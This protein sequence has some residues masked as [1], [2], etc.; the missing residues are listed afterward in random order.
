MTPTRPFPPDVF[1]FSPGLFYDLPVGRAAALP[2]V[3][4]SVEAR[5]EGEAAA[6][7]VRQRFFSRAEIPVEATYVFPLEEGAAVRGFSIRIGE[8]TVRGRILEGREAFELYEGAVVDGHGA[9]LLDQE[10]PN[11][12]TASVGN[13]RPGEEVEVEMEYVAVLHYE[14]PWL[15]WQLPTTVATRYA[16][17]Y[18]DEPQAGRPEREALS[19]P[20]YRC[21]PYGLRVRVDVRSPRPLRRVESPSH[22]LRVERLPGGARVE[23]AREEVALDRDLVL[24]VEAASS[25]EPVAR[26]AREADGAAVAMLSHRL[27]ADA[28]SEEAE[29][30]P[31]EAIFLLDASGSM[32]GDSIEQARRALELA[33]RTL[34]EGDFFNLVRF[35][36]RFQSLWESPRPYG[37]TS[38]EGAARWIQ[39]TEAS[40]GGTRI[41]PPLE[42][43][44]A[45]EP[46][47]PPQRQIVLLTDGQVSDESRIVE[48]LAREGKAVRVFTFGIGTAA[49]EYLVRELARVTG[50]AAA[51][52][53]PG[54]RIEARVLRMIRRLRAPDRRDLAIDWGTAAVEQAPRRA[55]GLFPGDTVTV[56]ARFPGEPPGK[57]AFRVGDQLWKVP[58][59]AG[60]RG[61]EGAEEGGP[62][63]TLWARE[64]IRDL[65]R[66]AAANRSRLVELGRRYGLVS[67]ATQYVAVDER[68]DAERTDQAAPLRPV[69]VALPAGWKPGPPALRMGRSAPGSGGRSRSREY[70]LGEQLRSIRPFGEP[71]A[72]HARG[73]EP[74]PLYALLLT[75][76]ADGSFPP[77]PPLR[78]RLGERRSA[79]EKASAAHGE[80]IAATA[81]VLALLSLEEAPRREE[82]EPAARK[83][84][85]WLRAHA[86]GSAVERKEGWIRWASEWLGAGAERA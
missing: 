56:F 32:K 20:S 15:R 84:E 10:R 60:E 59:G 52:I 79:F 66:E 74:D 40:M 57:V 34:R 68:P 45:A 61:G 26:L 75:Q 9:F 70:L 49:S 58:L 31:V 25:V 27:E 17:S 72:A 8:R 69:P 18:P 41:L 22:D 43:V 11:I 73:A 33:V 3:G 30:K 83:A 54:E 37:E 67:S 1:P 19:L 47:G 28:A 21:V 81:A 55:P 53:D 64:T 48:R 85:R 76:K 65:E 51:M 42:Q 77:S 78:E 24:R 5:L 36:Y 80:A 12:F 39:A 14:G 82:W 29:G 23:L 13:L 7:R 46:C 71:A 2:L 63:P 4:V 6:V 35:G 62:I 50:G 38:L 44:L 16:P 86:P